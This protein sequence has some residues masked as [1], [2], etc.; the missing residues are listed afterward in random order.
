M[1]A[2]S[3]QLLTLA[4]CILTSCATQI[5]VNTGPASLHVVPPNYYSLTI[6]DVIGSKRKT[7]VADPIIEPLPTE[8]ELRRK[9]ID[10]VFDN[11]QRTLQ[12]EQNR[13]K[14]KNDV[15]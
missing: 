7:K 9:K 3:A 13:L 4:V 12:L 8:E 14:A 15:R 2:N 6:P 1:D 10:E 5:P 11:I